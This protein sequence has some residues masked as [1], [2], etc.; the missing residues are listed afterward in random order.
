MENANAVFSSLAKTLEV[1]ALFTNGLNFI[2]NI[3]W[4]PFFKVPKA[5]VAI[6]RLLQEEQL[7]NCFAT[8]CRGTNPGRCQ[9]GVGRDLISPLKQAPK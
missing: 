8:F 5:L 7:Q 4:L 9:L 3:I 1:A 6:C 2:I